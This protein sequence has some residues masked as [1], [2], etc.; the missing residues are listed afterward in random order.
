MAV[1]MARMLAIAAVA[2]AAGILSG[3]GSSVRPDGAWLGCGTAALPSAVQ[4]RRTVQLRYPGFRPLLVTQRNRAVVRRWFH[5]VCDIMGH[6]YLPP[7]GSVWSCPNDVGLAYEGVF[8]AGNR[9]VAVLTYLA[10]GCEGLTLSVGTD[11]ASTMFAGPGAA[12][13]NRFDADLALV[14]GVRP[15]AISQQPAPPIRRPRTATTAE[16]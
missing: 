14:L 1:R 11:Q 5:D 16:P 2:L 3:C 13:A 12:A 9:R 4:V 15:G 6:P 8:Y 7:S 10:S